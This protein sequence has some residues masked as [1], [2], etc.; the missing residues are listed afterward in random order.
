MCHMPTWTIIDGVNEMYSI[1]S[2]G[3]KYMENKGEKLC[4]LWNYEGSPWGKHWS[5]GNW[6]L[7]PPLLSIWNYENIQGLLVKNIRCVCFP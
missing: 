6:Q 5:R 3:D 4:I 7:P 2:I 1:Y